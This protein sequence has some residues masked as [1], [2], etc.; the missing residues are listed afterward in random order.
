[1][2]R[3]INLAGHG[4][5]AMVSAKG[6]AM[7]VAAVL[8]LSATLAIAGEPATA[9]QSGK[10][11]VTPSK[12][13]GR[14]ATAAE[15]TAWDT[16]VRADFK[17]LPKGS[18]S[19]AAGQLVWDA[20][21]ASC[22]GSFGESNEVFTPIVGG[23]TA[24]DIKTGHVAALKP[25]GQ[26]P[27]RTTLM[28]LA[29]VSTLWDYI[30]RA[31]PWT[32]PKTLSDNEVYAV[33]AY[34]LNL[35]DIVPADFTLSDK[36]IAEVQ[37]LMPNRNGMVTQHGLWDV[38]GKP[39]VTSK[40]CM[41]DCLPE[42]AIRSTF[43]NALRAAFGNPAQ[44]H[45][46]IGQTHGIDTSAPRAAVPVAPASGAASSNAA[47]SGAAAG[48]ASRASLSAGLQLAKGNNCTACHGINNKILGPAFADVAGKY[49]NQ[50]GAADVLLKKIKQGG[51]GV[52]GTVPMPPQPASETDVRAIVAWLLDGAKQ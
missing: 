25:G 13:P 4:R 28:K 14:P 50:A 43:P 2:S 16:D 31:M 44:Q 7:L 19:V 22:H 17:G 49:R 18:G 35:G 1:M 41:K 48:T 23:T 21:C 45:R 29:T 11:A 24:D 20:R 33:T 12:L 51:S 52:W 36:N 30:K 38:K 8:G 46:S 9:G 10:A 34:I 6:R 47:A 15:I 3:P 37:Q 39:D 42:P 40:A 27:H 5:A 26:Q 32:A